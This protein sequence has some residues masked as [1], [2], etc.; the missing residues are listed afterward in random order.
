MFKL[1]PEP[2][3]PNTEGCSSGDFDLSVCED[4]STVLGVV[5]REEEKI[6]P[7]TGVP[8][9]VPDAKPPKIDLGVD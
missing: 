4:G 8:E 7:V 1:D 6:D 3:E 9:V 2:T 5:L